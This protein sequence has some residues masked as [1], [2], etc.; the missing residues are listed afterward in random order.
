[1][2]A[3]V[4]NAR[5]LGSS[6]AVRT[7]LKLQREMD[8]VLVFIIETESNNCL[9]ERLRVKLGFIGK[10]VVESSGRSGGLVLF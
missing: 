6:R 5:G 9:M 8:H 1:M 7:L 3:L 2:K 4:W 10:L